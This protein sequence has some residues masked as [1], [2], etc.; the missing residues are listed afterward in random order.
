MPRLLTG[1]AGEQA[2]RDSDRDYVCG[3]QQHHL[4]RTNRGRA[5]QQR[6][7]YVWDGRQHYPDD[8]IRRHNE[9]GRFA[10]RAT[11]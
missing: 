9:I 1:K 7:R 11:K 6:Q 4:A 3:Y 10:N 8:P 5:R 2:D